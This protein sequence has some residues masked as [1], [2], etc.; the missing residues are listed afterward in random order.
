MFQKRIN[1][2]RQ[3]LQG[4]FLSFDATI[5]VNALLER[6]ILTN[7]ASGKVLRLVPPLII[8]K[9]NIDELINNLKICLN[10]LKTT[11]QK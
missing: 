2:R 10:D 5:L 11:F 9:S 7:A 4:L 1:V 3:K 6:K 8:G